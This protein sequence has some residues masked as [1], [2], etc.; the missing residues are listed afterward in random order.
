MIDNV[1]IE[2]FK[3][4][5]EIKQLTLKPL[6]I[7]TGV[8]SS[9]K[10]NIMEAI[11]LFGQASRLLERSRSIQ[12]EAIFLQGDQKRYPRPIEDYIVYKKDPKNTLA[13]EINLKIDQD[14][15]KRIEN[16]S[17]EHVEVKKLLFARARVTEHH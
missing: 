14:V 4:I 3:S 13:I 1:S 12:Y 9:G 6:T 5:K 2:N 17:S 8:N 10:S 16:I 7:L 11:S 15:Q